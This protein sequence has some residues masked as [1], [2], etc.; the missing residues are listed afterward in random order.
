[1]YI[2]HVYAYSLFKINK[3]NFIDINYLYLYIYINMFKYLGKYKYKRG[4]A[5]IYY[6]IAIITRYDYY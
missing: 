4:A 2:Y 3:T 6:F 5:I 1:M